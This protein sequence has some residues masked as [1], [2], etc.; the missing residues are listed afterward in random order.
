MKEY[1]LETYKT[2]YV[3]SKDGNGRTQPYSEAENDWKVMMDK[4][5]E[6][7]RSFNIIEA[8]M[9]EK[10]RPALERTITERE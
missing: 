2:F 8:R 9:P 5:E 6:A 1:N 10:P 7:L 4:Q 3:P